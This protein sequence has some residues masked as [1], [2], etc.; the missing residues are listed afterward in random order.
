MD[1]EEVKLALG[2]RVDYG[3]RSV[4]IHEVVMASE[5]LLKVNPRMQKVEKYHLSPKQAGQILAQV[6]PKLGILVYMLKFGVAEE[7]VL[8][9]LGKHD[10]GEVRIGGI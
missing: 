4:V 9:A 10:K 2:Y 6:K 1:H 5:T 8:E 7:Q 3:P